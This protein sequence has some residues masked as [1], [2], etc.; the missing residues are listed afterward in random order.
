M[1][2]RRL[3]VTNAE[4][5]NT[6]WLAQ[7]AKLRN[8]DRDHWCVLNKREFTP[9]RD[10]ATGLPIKRLSSCLFT[11][12]TAMPQSAD[13]TRHAFN[14]GVEICKPRPPMPAVLFVDFK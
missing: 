2:L 3:P 14:T 4:H 6:W 5:L 10:V 11:N 1:S 7:V 13:Q 8:P 9:A 12:D